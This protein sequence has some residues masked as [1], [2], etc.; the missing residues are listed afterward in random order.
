MMMRNLKVDIFRL[1]F[2]SIIL[3]FGIIFNSVAIWVFCLKMQKWTE[4]RVFMINLLISDCFLLLTIPFRMYSTIEKWDLGDLTCHLIIS[5]YFMNKYIS[6]AIITLISIDRYICIK[7]P[8]ESRSLR[9]PKKAAVTCGLLWMLFT[10]PRIYFDFKNIITRKAPDICFQKTTLNPINII[11]YLSIFGFYTPLPILVFCSVE[12]IRI[13]KRKKNSRVQEQQSVQKSIYIVCTNLIV[14]L[15]CYLPVN[16]GYIIRFV[17]ES[18]KSDCSQ[19]K[20]IND[21]VHAAQVIADLNCCFDALCY[22][23]V[24]KE[25]WERTKHNENTEMKFVRH[26]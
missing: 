11:L 26:I 20:F 15:L 21:Y 9:S 6:I 2:F 3:V 10:I 16:I 7:F 22:Y 1:F 19:I 14:F 25:F 17:I 13:L 8:L 24:A 23:F 12:I 18:L 5:I 4:T